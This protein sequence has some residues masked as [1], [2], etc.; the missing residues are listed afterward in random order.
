MSC[1]PRRKSDG[2]T[3]LMDGTQTG[4]ADGAGERHRW[5]F[6]YGVDGD[7]RFISHLDMLR[8]FQRALA[9]AMLPVRYS[10]GFNPHPRL[11]IPLPRPVG[12]ASDAEMLGVEFE[13]PID[14]DEALRGL[15]RQTPADLH[16]ASARRMNPGERPAALQVRYRLETGERSR[17]VLAACVERLFESDEAVVERESRKGHGGRS[18][19]VRR[20]LADIHLADDTIE[21]SL[22]VTE[23]GT[24]R[25][26]EI[27]GLL[28]YDPATVNHRIRRMDV[29]WR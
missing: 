18:V 13:R 11:M 21:F 15:E 24:A 29:R 20:Y 4:K 16:M 8:M 25:P 10:E 5:A 19:N 22:R 27:A 17:G 6:V 3:D 23:S 9:R 12:V 7:L 26:A 1:G 2:R 28:G 14:P